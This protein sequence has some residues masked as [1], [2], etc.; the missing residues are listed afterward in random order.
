MKS[1][2]E[3]ELEDIAEQADEVGFLTPR[4]YGRLHGIAP[5]LLYYYIRNKKL[6]IEICKCGRKVLDVKETDKFFEERHAA[7]RK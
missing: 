6:R 5:Q 3:L 4:E 1:E 2:H 7:K